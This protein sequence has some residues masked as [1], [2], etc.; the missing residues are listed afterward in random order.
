MEVKETKNEKTRAEFLREL[1]LSSA[2]LMAFYCMGTGLSSCSKKEAD[3]APANNGNNNNNTKID[4]TLD[5]TSNDFK[6][7]KTEGEF[8]IKDALII[9]NA[10]GTYV[11]LS[12]ACTHEGTS[13]SFRKA[14]NDFRCPTHGSVFTTAGAVK[15]G[16]A[17]SALKTYKT[18][19]LEN[20]NKLRV[21]E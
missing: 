9:A 4:F 5:L 21:S 10:A 2:A 12:K 16:P 8:I 17:A 7:L 19:V 1:G 6:T 18:E 11:A 14:E 15:T 20:G 3:P 13:V